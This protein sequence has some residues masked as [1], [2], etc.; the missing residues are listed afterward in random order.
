M[1]LRNIMPGMHGLKGIQGLRE[2]GRQMKRLWVVGV[3]VLGLVFW[4]LLLLAGFVPYRSGY[5][6]GYE[7]GV[8]SGYTVAS[9]KYTQKG[10]FDHFYKES[11]N[12]RFVKAKRRWVF[13]R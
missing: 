2:E 5:I 6:E 9:G 7:V 11:P 8:I 12:K 10:A 1:P 4:V 13:E 3:F